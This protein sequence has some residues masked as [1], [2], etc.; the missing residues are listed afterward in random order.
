MGI[1]GLYSVLKKECPEQL[2]TYKF[3]ELAG[4]RISVD[5]SIFLYKYVCTAGEG[6][7]N[8]FILL[9]CMLKKHGI[10]VVC[11]FDGQ[12][13]VP[14]EKRME[15]EARRKSRQKQITRLQ[16]SI[17]LRN[18][19]QD[20]YY[21]PDI[22][23]PEDLKEECKMLIC[24]RKGK[25][26]DMTNYED[27]GDIANSL[28]R[29]IER[30]EKQTITITDN[31][32]N[33]AIEIVKMMGLEVYEAYGEAETVCAH[34]AIEGEVDGVLTEDTDVLAYGCPLMF[35]FKDF[36]LSEEKLYGLHHSSIIEALEMTPEEFQDLCIL[37]RC[38]YNRHNRD[39]QSQIVK[40][41]PPDGKNRKKP[42]GIGK[43]GALA[44]IREYRRM[45]EVVKYIENPEPLIYERC[46][47]LFTI[48]EWMKN[49][50]PPIPFN[51]PLDEEK[52]KDLIRKYNLSLSLEYIKSFW[53]PVKVFIGSDSEDSLSDDG[54]EE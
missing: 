14:P 18:L 10:K 42:V 19:I 39:G 41:F 52:I 17:R 29:V 22:T 9:L 30:I 5:I 36:S 15:Q 51:G 33:L 54:F 16:E 23:L 24:P 11:V 35:A 8:L 7:M 45:E 37:L 6:W 48:P 38:D 46:R 40:G 34:L 27:P 26:P 1:T 3:S 47:E 31:H 32:K 44:M 53:K 21:D 13:S 49:E 2:V 43:V 50:T 28:N 12:K 20:K 4:F 25:I